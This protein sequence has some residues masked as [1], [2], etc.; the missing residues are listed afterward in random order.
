M[1]IRDPLWNS[2]TP[3]D[4]IS[5]FRSPMDG[6]GP[7]EFTQNQTNSTVGAVSTSGSHLFTLK[8][9]LYV[10]FILTA[11]TLGV[12]F[13]GVKIFWTIVRWLKQ[14]TRIWRFVGIILGLGYVVCNFVFFPQLIFLTVII[15]QQI[16]GAF[17]LVFERDLSGK[18]K[19]KKKWAKSRIA[20]FALT[21]MPGFNHFD[22]YLDTNPRI[23]NLWAIAPVIYLFI[24][25]I[26]PSR[27][28]LFRFHLLS[29]DTILRIPEVK[30][31]YHKLGIGFFATIC[32][33]L[34]ILNLFMPAGS[35]YFTT[36]LFGT[37]T[38]LYGVDKFR[39][40][41]ILGQVLSLQWE[42]FGF[43]AVVAGSIASDALVHGS[44]LIPT[45]PFLY[46]I[47]YCLAVNDQ[48]FITTYLP[49][50]MNFRRVPADRPVDSELGHQA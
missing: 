47:V 28:F 19:Q 42:W 10:G 41:S 32:V 49:N 14:H 13:L 43:L 21:A 30:K 26:A 27:R 37:Y 34:S 38:L 4:E 16:F 6:T 24:R 46:R 1:N 36:T 17:R 23:Y 5:N 50:W 31:R 29:Q 33:L 25:G 35:K 8:E 7:L 45:A 44:V 15:P 48:G 20:F 12:P 39:E 11:I 2:P 18:I 9:F 40:R 22:E 3:A